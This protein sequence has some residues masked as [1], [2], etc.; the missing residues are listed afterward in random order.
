MTW[1]ACAAHDV[2]TTECLSARTNLLA[3]C[4]WFVLPIEQTCTG[5]VSGSICRS[6]LVAQQNLG[7]F[8]RAP[9]VVFGGVSALCNLS[10]LG[11][12]AAED[13]VAAVP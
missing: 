6:L 12:H 10:T 1:W 13:A 11:A 3:P 7:H 8:R 2:A 9:V 5:P 4:W